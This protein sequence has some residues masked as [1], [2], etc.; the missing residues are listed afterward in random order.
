MN[1]MQETQ[2]SIRLS[3]AVIIVI[4]LVFSSS[5]LSYRLGKGQ[6]YGELVELLVNNGLSK[7]LCFLA[8]SGID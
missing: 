5:F 3:H 6:A 2:V 7:Y 1:E 4:L 8:S